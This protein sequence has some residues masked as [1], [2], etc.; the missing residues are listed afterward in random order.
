MYNNCIWDMW[1][2]FYIY[3]T[4]SFIALGCCDLGI[5]VLSSRWL[6]WVR[7]GMH[8]EFWWGNVLENVQLEDSED[9]R[10]TLRRIL[11][12]SVEKM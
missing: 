5:Q 7:Q 10:I 3:K 6:G 11:G 1:N 2:W 12:K 4:S 8:T 9:G